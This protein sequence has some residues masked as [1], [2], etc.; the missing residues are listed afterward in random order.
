LLISAFAAR[1]KRKADE[2]QAI[3][4][5]HFYSGIQGS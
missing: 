3:P 4:P 1:G 2:Q 5:Q